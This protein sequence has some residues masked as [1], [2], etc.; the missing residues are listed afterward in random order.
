MTLYIKENIIAELLALCDGNSSLTDGF[1]SQRAS[2]AASVS[3]SWR[4][5]DKN[6]KTLHEV[7]CDKRWYHSKIDVTDGLWCDNEWETTWVPMQVGTPSIPC[8]TTSDIQWLIEVMASHTAGIKPL[9]QWKS[10]YYSHNQEELYIKW[11]SFIQ[12]LSV[13]NDY[14][15][16]YI[17]GVPMNYQDSVMLLHLKWVNSPHTPPTHPSLP[18]THDKIAATSQTTFL[19]HSNF[20]EVFFLRIQWTK[21]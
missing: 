3:I 14:R 1:P 12:V 16:T 10:E 20:T 17:P 18:P 4:H 21:F 7:T 13:I 5:L 8:N 2:N 9:P 15:W 19:F 6:W 11:V